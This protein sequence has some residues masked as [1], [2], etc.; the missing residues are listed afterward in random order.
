MATI[1]LQLVAISWIAIAAAIL[2][3]V[4]PR[5]RHLHPW[6]NGGL[7]ILCGFA[8]YLG[9]AAFW[10]STEQLMNPWLFIFGNAAGLGG[11]ILLT[12]AAY[13]KMPA[14]PTSDE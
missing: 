5:M 10:R 9:A 14:P 2:L 4:M 12:I 3:V 8:A 6:H 7:A 13:R 1:L 11:F